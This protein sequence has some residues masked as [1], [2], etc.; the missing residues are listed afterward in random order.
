MDVKDYIDTRRI[1][2]PDFLLFLVVFT[3][4]GIGLAM[5]YSASAAYAQ[6]VF[7]DSFYFLKRQLVWCVLGFVALYALQ[8]VDYRLLAKYTKLM[9][10]FSIIALLLVFVPGIG[11]SVKG[12]S[13]WLGSG[14]FAMQ[15]AEFVKVFLVIYLAKVFSIEHETVAGNV[16]RL[17]VPMLISAIVFVLILLQPDFSNAMIVLLI[18]VLM[19]FFSG[20][21]FIYLL[22]LGVLSIPMFYLL[23]YQV[24]YRRARILAFLDPW[25][26]RYGI[27]YHIV[28]SFIAFKIGG[29]FGVGLGNGTQKIQRLPEPHTDFIFAVIAE[30]AGL[31]GTIFVIALFCAFGIRGIRIALHAPDDFGRLLAVGLT[32]LVCTQAFINIAVVSGKLPTTGIPLPFISYGGSSFISTMIASGILLNI[33]RFRETVNEEIKIAGESM[34]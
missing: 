3:L 32:V 2:E 4:A 33:S 24:T 19:L 14:A 15:P 34:L 1:S 12:S 23:I 27:G 7:H 18:A 22:T 13:R 20:F 11:K 6:R 9:L 28:Q 16:M 10:F 17:L 30:E 25:A 29:L 5:S 31:V 26:H 21:P 8:V